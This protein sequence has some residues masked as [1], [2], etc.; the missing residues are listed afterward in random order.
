MILLLTVLQP[1][2]RRT[3]AHCCWTCAWLLMQ[4]TFWIDHSLPLLNSSC[5]YGLSLLWVTARHRISALSSSKTHVD[6]N[7]HVLKIYRVGTSKLQ[8]HSAVNCSSCNS[9]PAPARTTRLIQLEGSSCALPAIGK[10]H[11]CRT[12]VVTDRYNQ[13]ATRDGT[14]SKGQRGKCICMQLCWRPSM[15][16]PGDLDDDLA[17]SPTLSRGL[18]RRSD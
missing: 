17:G 18:P 11:W 12:A 2:C 4:Y 16:K 5:R 10:N 1:Q 9:C 3:P 14:T 6:P 15:G 7:Q 8:F 13:K